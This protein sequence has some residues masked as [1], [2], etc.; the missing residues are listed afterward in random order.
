MDDKDFLATI[1]I[2]IAGLSSSKR[3]VVDR[4]MNGKW[5]AQEAQNALGDAIK[6]LSNTDE[7]DRYTSLLAIVEQVPSFI[8]SVWERATKEIQ[9]LDNEHARWS[10]MKQLYENFLE[11]QKLKEENQQ[12]LSEAI[13]SGEINEPSTITGMRRSAGTRPPVTLK[14]FRNSNA[15]SLQKKTND[16]DDS[17]G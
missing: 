2:K 1:D 9:T 12:N 6:Q 3:N 7:E 15:D 13:S 11:N 10:E 16:A 14:D 17:E 8:L 5:H 4:L